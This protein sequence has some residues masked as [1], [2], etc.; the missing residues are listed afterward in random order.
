[1]N[2]SLLVISEE[3]QRVYK[4][5]LGSTENTKYVID[6]RELYPIINQV[7]NELLGL[8]IQ[9]S[10]KAGDIS[11]PSCAIATYGFRQVQQAPTDFYDNRYYCIMPFFPLSLPRNMGVWSVCSTIWDADLQNWIDQPPMIPIGT[12]DWDL[13]RTTGIND[14]G[15]FENQI[16]YY[17]EGNNIYFTSA[18]P[19]TVDKDNAT[20]RV[21][22]IR[23]LISDP[24]LYGESAPYPIPADMVSTLVNRVIDIL[25]MNTGQRETEPKLQDR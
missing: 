24:G 19:S 2:Q 3:I 10:I 23:L 7:A 17:V 16:G 14:S 20:R 13:L 11:I 22:K 25:K 4:R 21:V 5:A 6:R 1:M 15:L 18:P 8:T 9:N 12:D